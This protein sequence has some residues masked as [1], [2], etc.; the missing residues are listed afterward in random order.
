MNKLTLPYFALITGLLPII[1]ANAAYLIGVSN[2]HLPSCIPYLE[3]CTSISSTGRQPPESLVFRATIIPAAV[4]MA[5]YWHLNYAWLMAIGDRPT[6][7][8]RAMLWLGIIAAIFLIV[9]TVALGFI[10]PE[11]AMQRRIGV[12]FFF[13]F[14]FFAQ[15]LLAHRINQL[16]Q[17]GKYAFLETPYRAKMV[18]CILMLSL[19]VISTPLKAIFPDKYYLEMIIE[20]NFAL[21]MYLYFIVTFFAWRRSSFDLKFS[22][23]EQS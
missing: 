16:M 19:G 23:K 5:A 8:N 6:F 18:I 12:T 20:W 17:T 7:G 2:G 9:Y 11:Y 14:T 13:S 4:F 10:G 22:T 1:A 3:G 15:L 21:L